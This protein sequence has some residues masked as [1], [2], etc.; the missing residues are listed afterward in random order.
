MSERVSGM[1]A[2][3]APTVVLLGLAAMGAAVIV[4]GGA[5]AT[6]T[7]AH[8]AVA[9]I[10]LVAVGITGLQLKGAESWVTPVFNS[11]IL[12]LAVAVANVSGTRR[13]LWRGRNARGPGRAEESRDEAE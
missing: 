3:R 13:L 12:L 1:R 6:A 8:Q 2:K 9:P 11:G 7:K 5:N 4:V 10:F